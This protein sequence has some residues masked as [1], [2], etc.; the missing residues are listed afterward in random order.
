MTLP[1]IKQD[2]VPSV[3]IPYQG[4]KGDFVKEQNSIQISDLK[5]SSEPSISQESARFLINLEKIV[6]N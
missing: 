1:I 6:K 5:D 2:L 3:R 4:L